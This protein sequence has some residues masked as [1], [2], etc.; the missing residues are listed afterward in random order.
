MTYCQCG[1]LLALADEETIRADHGPAGRQPSQGC[2]DRVKLAVGART[3]AVQLQSQRAVR[4]NF[5]FVRAANPQL[6]GTRISYEFEVLYTLPEV[7]EDDD[8]APEQNCAFAS[9]KVA[10]WNRSC[11]LRAARA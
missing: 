3:Q 2:K 8:A 6:A 5:S 10:A 9:S 4:R 11:C 7:I 1:E